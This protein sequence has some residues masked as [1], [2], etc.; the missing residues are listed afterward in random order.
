MSIHNIS[1]KTRLKVLIRL[2]CNNELFDVACSKSGLA[3]GDAKKLLDQHYA[4]SKFNVT[5]L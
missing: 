1:I 3:A 5:N 2:L 4:I